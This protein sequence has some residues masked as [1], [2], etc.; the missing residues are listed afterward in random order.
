MIGIGVL[1]C[2]TIGPLHAEAA[3]SLDGARL[4]AV[5]DVRPE[6]ARAVADR[7]GVAAVA[8]LEELL[9][10]SEV[11]LVCVCTPSGTHAG[12]GTEIARAGR[13]VVLE[14]P[15]DTDLKATEEVIA[16]CREAGVV[17]SVIS[18]H[19][20]DAG[21]QRL[22]SALASGS[23]GDIVLAEARAWWYRT[24]AYYDAD[25]W[26]G[27]YALD[28]G[29]LSNQG[30]HLVDLLLYLLGPV[31]SVFAR[32]KTVAHEMEA[33]DLLVATLAFKSGVLGVVSVTTAS[34]PGESETLAVTGSQA[35][36]KLE[37]GAVATW[38]D[39]SSTEPGDGAPEPR[40]ASAALGSRNL[41]VTAHRAQL[42]DVV[43]AIR[44]H[45]PP[46]ITGEDGLAALALIQA[47]Y[48][49]ARTGKDVRLA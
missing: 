33:E 13:H 31:E 7:Y 43:S 16:T 30:V 6:R 39:A 48:E 46:A 35:H 24:Q 34:F 2:G 40:A 45:R 42:Q 29:A 15:V 19:R 12:L 18:Q 41:A 47:A 17:L 8:S 32:A 49:S 36:V 25:A 10:L 28:G 4:V 20:F 9:A 38:R 26:R 11:D 21:V 37:A 14:K 1:G 22:R 44:D 27:T 3:S 23:L 5:G